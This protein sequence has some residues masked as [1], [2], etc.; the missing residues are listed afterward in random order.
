[1]LSF[2]TISPL[3]S[4]QTVLGHRI[5]RLERDPLLSP[6]PV[7]VQL[8]HRLFVLSVRVSVRQYAALLDARA[9][10]SN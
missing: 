9:V 10:H 1:M 3:Q 5:F 4:S 8:V 7:P 2:P 6:H